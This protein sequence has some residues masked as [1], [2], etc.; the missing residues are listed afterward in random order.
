M[1]FL[2]TFVIKGGE[3]QTDL[4]SCFS[5]LLYF[6]SFTILASEL[7]TYAASIMG[8]APTGTTGVGGILGKTMGVNQAS[9]VAKGAGNLLNRM[10]NRNK[11]S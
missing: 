1:N 6:G 11:I 10:R 9:K 8:G 2:N 5:I 4:V 7:P 3:I